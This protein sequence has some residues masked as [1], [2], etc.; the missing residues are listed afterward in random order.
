MC[1]HGRTKPRNSPRTIQCNLK[2]GWYANAKKQ[3]PSQ[4]PPF[5]FKEV[6]TS[7][8]FLM[9]NII[10][11]IKKS[12]GCVPLN[13]PACRIVFAKAQ[14]IAT[15][16]HNIFDTL[17]EIDSHNVNFSPCICNQK[18]FQDLATDEIGGHK[19][20]DG[21]KIQSL[22]KAENLIL[23]ASNKESLWPNEK[24][25]RRQMLAAVSSIVPRTREASEASQVLGP[26]SKH[27]NRSINRYR[28]Y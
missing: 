8:R 3:S 14:T 7:L 11:N 22:N 19:L 21:T 9:S 28:K 12:G 10:Q 26:L 13:V 6:L 18:W 27:Q 20:I 5:P 16:M 24:M 23:R 2:N 15:A 4:S 1:T 17:N 25:F